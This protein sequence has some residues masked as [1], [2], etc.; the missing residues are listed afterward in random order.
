MARPRV[1]RPIRIDT[2]VWFAI[3]RQLAEDRNSFPNKWSRPIVRAVTPQ[4]DDGRR[5]AK[6]SVGELVT[7]EADAFVDGHDAIVCD[8]RAR[9]RSGTKW[10]SI[11]MQPLLDDRWR[12]TLPITEPGLYRFCVR[13]RVDDFATWRTDLRARAEAGQDLTVELEVGA[14]LVVD[15]ARRA[16]AQDGR[17]LEALAEAI[18]SSRRGLEGSAPTSL[19]DWLSDLSPD[20]SLATVLFS[21]Q[22][23]SVMTKLIDPG[24]GAISPT[25][26]LEAE[27]AKARCSAWYELFPRST[28]DDPA[29]HGTL[30]DV[31]R[32][33]DYVEQLGF[34]VLYLPPIHPIGVTARKGRDG[35]ARP[36]AEDPGSPWAIGGAAGGHTAIHPELGTIDDFR[37][38]VTDAGERGIDVAIDLAFQA[39]PDHPWVAEHP[40]WFRHRPDGSIRYAENPPKRYEDIY[41]FDFESADWQALWAALRDVVSFWIEQGVTVFR[42]DNPHTKPFAFWEWLIASIR[43]STPEVIFL[44][45]A[46]TRPRIMEELARIGFTQSYTYF[47]WRTTKWE[48]ETYM[49]ELTRT[50]RSA[51]L[52]PNLWPNTPDILSEELQTGGRAAFISRLVLAATLSSSYGI[53]GPAFELQ[54]H[55]PRLEGSEEYLRSEKYEIRTWDLESPTS[56]SGLIGLINRIRH[57]HE[58]LQFNDQLQFHRTDN[59]QLIAYSKVRDT[60]D[61]KDIILTVV[62]LDHHHSQ[63]GWVTTDLAAMGLSPDHPF[64][65]HDLLSDAWFT[66]KGPSNFVSLDPQASPC[67]VLALHQASS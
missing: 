50:G 17:R 19:S 56:L 26:C 65:A 18:R 57:D 9:H 63:A 42:V 23:G 31:R 10:T 11:P 37:T 43:S 54:E 6:T 15:A 14:G 30:A 33:L 38:L 52:R 59:E 66:W 36:S 61:G 45:E 12:G 62:N 48:I 8:L 47:T 53:Y 67:H 25:L 40:T 16:R 21:E 58:A 1:R 44:S 34:D 46:F 2:G 5:P 22:L 55:L 27:R 60:A 29:R 13:A 39:S 4:V 64:T 28:S 24:A 20:A 51:Y 49:T 41:P 32:R 35:S 7:V 3:E